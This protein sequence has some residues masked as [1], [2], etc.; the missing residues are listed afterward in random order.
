MTND[1]GRS[2]PLTLIV[3]TYLFYSPRKAIPTNPTS[4]R[5][6]QIATESFIR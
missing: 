4:A 3:P 1:K 6:T 2:S 5:N